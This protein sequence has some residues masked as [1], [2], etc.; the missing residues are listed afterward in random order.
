MSHPGAKAERTLGA[1]EP[2]VSEPRKGMS[3]KE[4]KQ[5]RKSPSYMSVTLSDVDGELVR[6]PDGFPFPGLQSTD[7]LRRPSYNMHSQGSSP[8]LGDQ[9]FTP[10][11]FTETDNISSV[12]SQQ[13]RHAGSSTALRPHYDPAKSPLAISQQTSASSARDMALRKGLP[14]ISGTTRHVPIQI[15]SLTDLDASHNRQPSADSKVSESSKL[16][17][18]SIRRINSIPRR[19]PSRLDH[20]TLYPEANRTFHSVSP[21]SALI[22][23]SLPKHLASIQPS[24]AFNKSKWWQR[25]NSPKASPEPPPDSQLESEQPFEESFSSIKV[26]VKR[27]K[28]AG[29]GERNWFDGLGDDSETLEDLQHPEV[30]AAES[31]VRSP[32][33]HPM[34]I[35]EIMQQELRPS[36]MAS[37]KSSFSNKSQ[38]A[39]P[40]GRKLS[41]RLD[42]PP[43][44]RYATAP[45]T[46]SNGI[47]SPASSLSPQTTPRGKVEA[48]MSFLDV[49][50]SDDDYGES[51]APSEVQ[52]SY[53]RHRIRAS[54]ERAKY[55]TE[56]SVGSA[57]QAQPVRPR[58]IVNR[59]PAR[60][61]RP[62]SGASG[63]SNSSETVP[64]VPRIPAS[65]DR[66]KPGQ[67]T[68]S[69][70][71][72]EMME[73]RAAS[74]E[75]TI[76]SG[77]ST[78]NDINA[79][80]R[81]Q[82]GRAKR[83]SSIRANKL[84]KVTQEEEKLLEAMR[85]KRASIRQDDFEKGFKTALHLQDIVARPKTAGADGRNSIAHSRSSIYG[86]RSSISPVPTTEYNLKRTL[87]GSRLSASTDDLIIS[88]TITNE[89]AFPFPNTNN[90]SNKI[91]PSPSFDPS[92]I[93]PTTPT[94]RNSPLTPPPGLGSLG[95][96]RGSTLSPGRSVQ[97]INKLGHER[98][99]TISSSVVM[100]D[101]VEQH[102]Q[103]LDEENGLANWAMDRW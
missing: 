52:A 64:P 14:Q 15:K 16:S 40:T 53:R 70:R 29:E 98:K 8:L 83:R 69:M 19:R 39:T 22:S 51:S 6:T 62:V 96:W 26:N 102:A 81:P 97:G 33:R 34:S 24:A 43:P 20:P 80:R 3:R 4:R 75:S 76:D 38:H 84:M 101:G 94:S 56:V 99:R 85:D 77:E 28:V 41:F 35:H 61:S 57:Q 21:P 44:R 50:S 60:T 87:T 30:A 71:W 13:A 93:L 59:T 73:E 2:G 54:I 91:S 103:E 74:T 89:D 12:S 37:R 45:S 27:P 23:S 47:R 63:R 78:F 92:D 88:T 67:R 55:N 31:P 5:L 48:G 32:E 58:S 17:G 72:R 90:D 7:T 9:Y 46:P 49:S 25:K 82:S 10:N 100:L 42:S 1:S 65:P 95:G 66:P 11:E 79:A 18:N 68:S 36:Q 86:S